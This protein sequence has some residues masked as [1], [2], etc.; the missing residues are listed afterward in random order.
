MGEDQSK[1]LA[2]YQKIDEAMVNKDTATLEEILD[3]N[4]ILVHMSGYSQR[5]EEWLNQIE[6]EQMRYFKTMPQKTTVTIN[7][8]IAVLRCSTK[9]D[10]RIYGMRNIWSMILTMHFEKRGDYW[11]PVKAEARSN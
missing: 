5:K 11:H 4:Y 10:A 6:D 7:G 9:L 2:V 1:I 8:N 3:E